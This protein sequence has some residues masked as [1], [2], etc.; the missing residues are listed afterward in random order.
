ME[1]TK[2]NPFNRMHAYYFQILED[3]K[4]LQSMALAN[5]VKEFN[6]HLEFM[7]IRLEQA[8]QEVK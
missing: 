3:A 1:F 5:D 6:K 2:H 8:K 4:F 7:K